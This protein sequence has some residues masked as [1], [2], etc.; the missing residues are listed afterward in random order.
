MS[1]PVSSR[2][3]G[4]ACLYGGAAGN[5]MPRS[6]R[7][8]GRQVWV[9]HTPMYSCFIVML[10]RVGNTF[11]LANANVNDIDEPQKQTWPWYLLSL[12]QV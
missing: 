4:P 7:A 8:A 9:Y 11:D 12:Q 3:E 5:P 10:S 6:G 1:S 2:N